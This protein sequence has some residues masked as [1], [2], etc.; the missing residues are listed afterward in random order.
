MNLKDIRLKSVK[1]YIVAVCDGALGLGVI[2]VVMIMM[3]TGKT[4]FFSKVTTDCAAKGGGSKCETGDSCPAGH[5]SH[6][7]AVC[8]EGSVCCA[9]FDASGKL[10]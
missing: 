7:G 3:L 2:L 10:G 8:E 6:V 1:D 4:K 9:P 5:I